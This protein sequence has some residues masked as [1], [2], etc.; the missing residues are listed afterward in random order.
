[1]DT[2]VTKKPR[3]TRTY[4]GRVD[5]VS[6]EI[7]PKAKNRKRNRTT[8]TNP[9]DNLPAGIREQIQKKDEQ[10]QAL[11]KSLDLYRKKS[12]ADDKLIHQL[13]ESVQSHQ[14]RWSSD[15]E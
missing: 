9:S 15:P 14:K 11:E 1:M 2:G 8:L 7:I 12:K 6:G 4:L 13:S 3:S 10:I 5:P